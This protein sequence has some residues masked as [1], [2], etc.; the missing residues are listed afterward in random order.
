MDTPVLYTLENR[1]FDKYFQKSSRFLFPLIRIGG[2]HSIHPLKTF[3]A[4][5]GHIS[6]YQFKLICVYELQNDAAYKQYEKGVLFNNN[7]FEDYKEAKNNKGVYIFSTRHVQQDV[8]HFLHGKY[9]KFSD[10]SKHTILNHF[11]NPHTREYLDS[12]L[13]PEI[14]FEQYADKLDVHIGDLIA[15]GELCNPY[16]SEAETFKGEAIEN[17]LLTLNPSIHVIQ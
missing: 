13:N 15:V 14:Y 5:E 16:N 6:L 4:W 8:T 2:N 3:I 7:Y 12:W 9:S 10:N 17:R 1:L 11:T